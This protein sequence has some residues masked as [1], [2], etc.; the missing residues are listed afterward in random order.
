MN[1]PQ[2]IILIGPMGAGKTTIGRQLAKTLDLDF[3][4][5]DHEIEIRTGANIPLIFDL[6]GEEGFRQREMAV[7]DELSQ[8]KQLVLATGGG[9][10]LRAENRQHLHDRGIVIYLHAEIDQLLK[11]THHDRNRPLLQTGNPRKKFEELMSLREP[12]YRE[13]AH[14]IINTDQHSINHTVSRIISALD[15]FPL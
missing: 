5:S 15:D 8:R 1:Q 7:I 3:V 9:V 11:R 4:D 13:T 12:L 6:E 10:V 14:L 2:R